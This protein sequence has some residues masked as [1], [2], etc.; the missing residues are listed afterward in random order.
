M[1]SRWS[2]SALATIGVLHLLGQ[3]AL[4][5][6]DHFL[7]LLQLVAPLGDHVL[8]LVELPLALEDFLP[9]LIELLFDFR[10]LA[11]RHLLG[12]DLGL[13]VAGVGLDFGLFH[14]HLRFSFG[15]ALSQIPQELEHGHAH[16]G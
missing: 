3:L 10:F 13:L 9:R 5:A 15:V 12:L 14:D 6:L 2:S 11:E 7:L 8:L 16:P 4:V 1:S